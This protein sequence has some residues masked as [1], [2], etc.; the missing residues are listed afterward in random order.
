VE[1][2]GGA[3]W[4]NADLTRIFSEKEAELGFLKSALICVNLWLKQDAAKTR[5]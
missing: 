3:R 1:I 4:M 5:L 2:G